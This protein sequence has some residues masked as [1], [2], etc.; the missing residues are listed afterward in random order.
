VSRNLPV[1]LFR[2]LF[3]HFKP[4]CVLDAWKFTTELRILTVWVAFSM[5]LYR[6][7]VIA[8]VN[9]NTMIPIIFSSRLVSLRRASK[10]L[11]A[12][13]A[14]YKIVRDDRF[15]NVRMYFRS[16]IKTNLRFLASQLYGIEKVF[17]N[18]VRKGNVW[19]Q[20]S[21]YILF[22]LIFIWLPGCFEENWSTN[23]R[24]QTRFTHKTILNNTNP[25]MV[26]TGQYPGNQ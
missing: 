23:F 11:H 8:A 20:I 2:I 21:S 16:F 7:T 10:R 1:K 24:P 3:I 22:G 6:R 19:V 12:T 5:F 25:T 14:M 18:P 17:L 4:L 26:A 9:P 15:R 13:I